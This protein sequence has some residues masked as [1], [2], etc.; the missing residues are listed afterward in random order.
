MIANAPT[1][2]ADARVPGADHVA[3][4]LAKIGLVL[5]N[6]AWQRRGRDGSRRRRGRSWRS[7]APVGARACASARSQRG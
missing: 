5:R 1:T 3:T 7:C 4:G 2:A 6:E